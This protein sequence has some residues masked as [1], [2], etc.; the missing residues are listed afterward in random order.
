MFERE[1]YYGDTIKASYE[2][3]EKNEQEAVI[4]HKIEDEDGKELTLLKTSWQAK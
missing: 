3:K 1:C 4:L 2:I